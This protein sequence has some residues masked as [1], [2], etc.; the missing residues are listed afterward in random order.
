MSD[1]FSSHG[2]EKKVEYIELIY[3]LIFVYILGR[4][5]SLLHVIENGFLRPDL[6]VTYLLCT[7]IILQV[8]YFTVLLINRYGSNGAAEY[9]CIFINMYLLY[10]MAQGTNANWQDSYLRYNL[11]W[12]LILLNLAV[13]YLLKLRKNGGAAPWEDRHIRYH[14]RMLFI[15]AA[16]V[17]ISLPLYPLT[18]QPLSLLA[19]VFGMVAGFLT[20][21]VDAL[22][23]VDFPHLTERVMLFVVFTFGE[24]IVGIAGYFEGGFTFRTVYYS[25]MGFLIV[26]GLF[27]CYGFFYE[28]LLDREKS[29]TGTGFMLLHIFL[30]AALNNITGALEFMREPE[31]ST[32]PKHVFLVVSFLV[33]FLFLALVG[34]YSKGCYRR[35]GR[36]AVPLA[37]LS[38]AFVGL[39]AATYRW[40]E[41]SIAVTV[42]YVFA[43]F[44]ML[45]LRWRKLRAEEA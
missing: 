15:Q 43:A 44:G 7:V 18:G 10:Y 26:A 13:Q 6:Y 9:V 36:L 41:Y 42:L 17:L 5:N 24:M 37:V 34:V 23:S 22:V 16:L 27:L 29:T 19:L 8:W 28:R 20:R 38:L 25:L 14:A 40:P 30:I 32:V 31:I 11:A 1:L 39:M 3:D 21:K 45:W 12:G 2:N 35:H 4:S 33:Y